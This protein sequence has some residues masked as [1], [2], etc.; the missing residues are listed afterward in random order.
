MKE[1]VVTSILVPVDGS[2]NSYKAID[3][4]SKLAKSTKATV[5]LLYVIDSCDEEQGEAGIPEGSAYVNDEIDTLAQYPRVT[6]AK[7][8]LDDA[9]TVAG[10]F[11]VAPSRMIA[12][13]DVPYTIVDVATR[14]QFNEGPHNVSQQADGAC[15][16]NCGGACPLSSASCTLTRFIPTVP[17]GK[18]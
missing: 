11:N 16:G 7:E 13:G 3:Y 8:I 9:L 10:T 5:T 2:K 6:A 15:F 18:A 4:A 17:L 1:E 14:H 12:L